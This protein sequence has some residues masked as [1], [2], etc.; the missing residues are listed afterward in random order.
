MIKSRK[1]CQGHLPPFRCCPETAS[2]IMAVQLIVVVLILPVAYFRFGIRSAFIIFSCGLVGALAQVTLL[3]I[4]GKK[5]FGSNAHSALLGILA[6]LMLPVDVDLHIAI[7][8]AIAAVLLGK[9]IFGGLGNY[10][11]HPALLGTAITYIL[12]RDNILI[13]SGTLRNLTASSMQ[14]LD[15]AENIRKFGDLSDFLLGNASG[16]ICQSASLF[17]IIMGIYFIYRGY[18]NWRSVVIYILTI[19]ILSVFCPLNI[20]DPAGRD[21]GKMSIFMMNPSLGQWV[22]FLAYEIFA[23]SIIFTAFILHADMA[24]RPITNRGQYLFAC[25]AAALTI[26]LQFYTTIP[27]PAPAAMLIAGMLSRPI[28]N[29]TRPK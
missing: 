4:S 9:Y 8:A 24:S 15:L 22:T 6:A 17:F 5:S 3:R 7:F 12:F 2:T 14:N 26:I 1:Y 27:L 11:L 16:C 20:I 18:I 13:V 28:D 25:I 19:S 10:F 29:L 21:I 23:G